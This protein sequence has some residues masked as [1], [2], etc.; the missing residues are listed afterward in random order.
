VRV[1]REV[2]LIAAE[3]T[4]HSGRL[5]RYF[6]I[7]TPMISYHAFNERARV[8]R[9][10]DALAAGD[11][12]LISDAGTPGISDPGQMLVA[13]AHE[14]GHRVSP[15]PGPSSLVAAVSASGLVEGPFTFLGFLPRDAGERR[16]LLSAAIA[17]GFALMLFESPNR[18]VATLEEFRAAIGD[19]RA[20]VAR[21]I[22]KLHEE[23]IPGKLSSLAAHFSAGDVLGEVVI[24]IGARVVESGAEEPEA[25]IARLLGLGMKP[26]EAAKEGAALSGLPRSDLYEIA[27]R[28]NK[29]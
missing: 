3:D 28:L 17:S 5:L 10:L 9:L 27:V 23:I 12:A 21:E 26:S 22:T 2:T 14:A 20:V 8:E 6:D 18:L 13:A 16:K 7:E 24:V 29:R 25:M 1:L 19:E 4:R 15:I 11:V